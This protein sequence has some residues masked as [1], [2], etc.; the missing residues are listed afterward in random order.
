MNRFTWVFLRIQPVVETSSVGCLAQKRYFRQIAPVVLKFFYLIPSFLCQLFVLKFPTSLRSTCGH[1]QVTVT[2]LARSSDVKGQRSI[3]LYLS[4]RVFRIP[5][6]TRA[7]GFSDLPW[8][9]PS[10]SENLAG[11]RPL[12][13]GLWHLWPRRRLKSWLKGNSDIYLKV[14]GWKKK[15]KKKKSLIS[16][17]STYFL[18]F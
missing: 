8:F 7:H 6:K 14:Q 10:R 12:K 17:S 1:F 11:S 4:G 13:I 3:K 9:P 2:W 16:W 5:R 15:I 18:G